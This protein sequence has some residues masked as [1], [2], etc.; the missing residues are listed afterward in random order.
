MIIVFILIIS[1]GISALFVL[2]VLVLF[3]FCRFKVFYLA[4]ISLLRY[5]NLP[6]SLPFFY[7]LVMEKD[8]IPVINGTGGS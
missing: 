5:F 2:S 4:N 3:Y 7:L 6:P 8:E 1:F